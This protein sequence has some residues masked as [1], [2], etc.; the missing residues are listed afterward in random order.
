MNAIIVSVLSFSAA[1]AVPRPIGK[2]AGAASAHSRTAA[3]QA[4]RHEDVEA[5]RDDLKKMRSLVQQMET[6]V[7]F[8]DTTQSP[9]RHQF[10]LEIDMW[11]AV[12]DHMERRLKM[13]EFAKP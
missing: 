1:A 6:N 2:G 5:L 8:V 12:I 3:A 10:Q 11:K 9:L 4:V 7:A 13:S